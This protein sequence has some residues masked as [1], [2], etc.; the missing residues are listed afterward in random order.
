MGPASTETQ[1]QHTPGSLV[2][3]H[4]STPRPT[5]PA[6]LSA[7]RHPSLV[8]KFALLAAA[9]AL[10]IAITAVVSLTAL[11]TLQHSARE[12]QRSLNFV[13][14]LETAAVATKAIANDERGYLLTGQA[15]FID[16]I[17]TRRDKVTKALDS[18]AGNAGSDQ[19]RQAIATTSS[20][21]TT[22]NNALDAEFALFATNRQAATEAALGA[23]RDL[24]KAYEQSLDALISG[25]QQQAQQASDFSGLVGHNRAIVLAVLVVGCAVVLGLTVAMWRTIRRSTGQVLR[26]LDTIIAGDL[27]VRPA[28]SS[29]DELGHI[30]R[31]LADVVKA[32]RITI[33]TLTECSLTVSDQSHQLQ[34]VATDITTSAQAA[35]REAVSSS[36]AVEQIRSNV[37]T[38]AEGAQLMGASIQQIVDNA[39]EAA[40][41]ASQAVSVTDTT[42]QSVLRLGE[43]SAEIGQVVKVINSI[44]EQTNLLALNATIEAA[45]AGEAGKGFAVVANE[46]KDLAQETSKATE[47]ITGRVGAIQNDITTA[48]QAIAQ[49]AAVISEINDYQTVV[50]AAVEEQSSTTADMSNNVH[51]AHAS[52]GAI[53]DNMARLSNATAATSS[54]SDQISQAATRLQGLSGQLSQAVEKI[55][56]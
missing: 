8:G 51:Q 35:Q 32:Q 20:Q 44:A 4:I 45:R 26:E 50:V 30:S 46:V 47:D 12:Q 18:A 49:I 2:S 1:R 34:Q 27:G 43:S 33:S 52:T 11:N 42:N 5:R 53:G 56:L 41:V 16:E 21:I 6:L 7:L 19:Q 36:A 13:V 14:D 9:A 40:R 29:R 54:V 37:T 48:T 38:V 10:I 55:R 31:R 28:L 17:H 39:R 24:R 15:K 25:Q 3:G 22:W 23:N